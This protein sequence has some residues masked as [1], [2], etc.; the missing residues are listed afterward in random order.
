MKRVFAVCLLLSLGAGAAAQAQLA[1]TPM[2]FSPA[3]GSGV[4][5]FAT[6][7]MGVNDDAKYSGTAGTSSPMAFG[8]TIL[9]GVSSFKANVTAN[10]VDTKVAG[11]DNEATF[12]GNL[13]VA[14]YQGG[15]E[16]PVYVDLMVGVGYAKF[17]EGAFESKTMNFP[18]SIPIAYGAQLQGGS[19]VE[20]WM[21]P[22]V[23]F[24]N[25]SVGGGDSE[26]DIGFGG[27]F[28]I[29]FY[30][31]MGLG[32]FVNADWSS[33]KFGTATTSTQPFRVGAGLAWKFS[34]P[35]FAPSK[36]LIGG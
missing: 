25:W 22:R 16:T 5:V 10:Y 4:G 32:G 21:A 26:S 9:L 31:A 18:V 28:G 27:G 17:G 13:G 19:T 15:P 8:G 11:L 33:T 6:W 24:W 30:S 3:F 36:G 1:T 7:G 2:W 20:V 35:S 12:G 29:N 23:I 34:V 14:L